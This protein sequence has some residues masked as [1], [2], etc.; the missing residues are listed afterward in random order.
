M[1]P[2]EKNEWNNE[3]I[4][5][6]TTKLILDW[7]VDIKNWTINTPKSIQ[8]IINDFLDWIIEINNNYSQ[9]IEIYKLQQKIFKQVEDISYMIDFI[10]NHTT[11]KIENNNTSWNII[12]ILTCRTSTTAINS[13]FI[14][15]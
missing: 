2:I 11:P 1:S 15:I 12:D 9:K 6:L 13:N 4:P 5:E 14:S 10:L 7:L 3:K 8:K